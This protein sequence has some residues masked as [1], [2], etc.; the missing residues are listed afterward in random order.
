M[1]NNCIACSAFY[2]INVTILVA[3]EGVI[4]RG[5]HNVLVLVQQEK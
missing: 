1:C 4:S 2:T 3:K 5:S